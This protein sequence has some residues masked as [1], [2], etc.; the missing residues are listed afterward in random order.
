MEEDFILFEDYLKVVDKRKKAEDPRTNAEY[1]LDEFHMF[2]KF[3][4]EEMR[5][6]W[7]EDKRARSTGRAAGNR[8]KRSSSP[9]R[10][11][12]FFF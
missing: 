9:V 8:L 5:K 3:K 10:H 1:L 4:K 6:E 11:Q 7:R 12:H 2:E